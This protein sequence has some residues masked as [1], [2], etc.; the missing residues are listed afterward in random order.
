MICS[1]C[2]KNEATVH[3]VVYKNGIKIEKHLCAECAAHE[4]NIM[5][6]F[7]PKE[8]FKGLFDFGLAAPDTVCGNCGTTLRSFRS[9][10]KLGCSECY[11]AFK[12]E[13]IPVLTSCHGNS[14]H[15]GDVPIEAGEASQKRKRID[16]LKECIAKAVAE[17]NYEEAAK[18]RD[19]IA[20][21]RE[22]EQ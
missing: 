12:N 21:L 6:M 7:S 4:M 19:E 1:E 11:N 10:G 8:F 20:K 18:F 2:G 15:K 9:T 14:T 13:I 22:E 17:E 5:D 16:E 3:S